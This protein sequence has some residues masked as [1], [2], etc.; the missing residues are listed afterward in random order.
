MT[1][2]EFIQKYRRFRSRATEELGEIGE[3]SI[4]QLF[5]LYLALT[6]SSDRP[7][8]LMDL[9]NLFYGMNQHDDSDPDSDDNNDEAP[10][11]FDPFD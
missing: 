9:M 3:D 11:T 4:L 7:N 1:S 6:E 2:R 5:S 8:P 10:S